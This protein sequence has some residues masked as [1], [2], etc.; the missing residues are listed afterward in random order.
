MTRLML[1]GLAVTVIL[2]GCQKNKNIEAKAVTYTQDGQEFEGYIARDRSTDEKRPGILVIHEWTGLG[3]YVKSRTRQLAGL[4]YVAFA[5]DMYGKGV[6]AESHEEAAKLSGRYG[7]DR[8]LMRSR[9]DRALEIL[10]DNEYVNQD[11]IAV[12]GYC[13]GGM[14]A[15]ELAL[16]GADIDG[17]VAFHAMLQSPNLDDADKIKAKLLIH[18][19]ADDKFIP[20]E[21]VEKFKTALDKAGVGY[22]FVSHEGAVHAFTRPSATGEDDPNIKYNKEADEKSWASM[23]K[24]LREIFR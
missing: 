22:E 14:S 16:S 12:I 17:V 23:K 5:M 1:I 7:N 8:G 13:F 4:G 20:D 15:I 21:Q 18:H 24:F 2:T 10:K 9:M 3:D 6:R 19:G 11:R